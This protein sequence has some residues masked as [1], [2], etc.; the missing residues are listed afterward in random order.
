[1]CNKGEMNKD[2]TEIIKLVA[3][4]IMNTKENLVEN[5]SI[6]VILNMMTKINE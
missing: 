3:D 5:P 2:M 6:Y 4:A 1:M